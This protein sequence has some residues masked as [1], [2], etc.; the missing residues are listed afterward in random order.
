MLKWEDDQ[1]KVKLVVTGY[2][3]KRRKVEEIWGNERNRNIK[4]P[5]SKENRRF[6]SATLP[7]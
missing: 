2:E 3:Q 1:M 7:E 6:L 5:E 4:N